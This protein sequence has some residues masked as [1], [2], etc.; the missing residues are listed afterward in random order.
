[1]LESPFWYLS[2]EG[3]L[4]KL[5]QNSVEFN[6]M[7]FMACAR[8]LEW[9]MKEDAGMT[10]EPTEKQEIFHKSKCKIRVML[11]GNRSGKTTGL[12]METRW[13]AL[14]EH[15]Y[16]DTR[17]MKTIWVAGLDKINML[18]GTIIP[19]FQ[20]AI[21]D[22]YIENYDRKN[23][24]MYLKNGKKIIFKSC[25]SGVSKFQS[26]DVDVVAFDEEPPESIW[27]ECMMRTIDRGGLMYI[28]ETPT[29]GFSW[30][31]EKLWKKRDGETIDFIVVDTDDNPHI[32]IE[33]SKK[34][35]EMLSPEERQMRKEGRFVS[36]GGTRVF[37][38]RLT[39]PLRS[40]IRPPYF[41]GDIYEGKLIEEDAH[42]LRCYEA[43]N[44]REAY[45]IGFDTSEGMG[46]PSAVAVVKRA[47]KVKLVALYSRRI[48]I[49]LIYKVALD[50]G[51]TFPNNLLT[52]ERNSNGSAVLSNIRYN[53]NGTIYT[54]E[55]TSEMGDVIGRK[56][57]W[58]TTHPSK[59]KMIQD[60]KDLINGNLIEIP[61]E[62]LIS[63]ME[64]YIQNTKGELEAS[65][66][67]DDLVI[68][69]MLAIQGMLS[70]Q[71]DSFMPVSPDRYKNTGRPISSDRM[72]WHNF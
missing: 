3:N 55:D 10:Y 29:N 38:E 35:F 37:A 47:D 7:L 65:T 68:A 13:I 27:T 52:M 63:Q 69:V 22:R 60:F 31:Y 42:F 54:Q 36:V 41:A 5:I 6:K 17:K 45:Y 43:P 14:D 56:L 25:D 34:V 53:Y 58:R 8:E 66:G 71:A 46:D 62:E 28:A 24:T 67:Y 26:A 57:G 20:T 40:G 15:P 61:D 39:R 16:R 23:Y 9:R 48:D 72:K 33:E 51:K 4:D 12:V 11:G 70:L 1:M 59:R 18:A 32:P 64:N 30:V 49:E 2:G 19:R 21:P 44:D 50:F